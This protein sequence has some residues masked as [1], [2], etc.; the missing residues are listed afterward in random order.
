MLLERELVPITEAVERLVSLQAQVP[1]P[2]YIGLW[3]RL[4]NFH[5]GNLT[6][7]M[8]ERRVVR[9][10]LMRSILHLVTPEDYLLLRPALI[11][12]LNAFLGKLNKGPDLG[13][14]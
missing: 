11:R 14:L 8:Q 4:R 7:L 10:T 6:R 1:N 12:V 13:P 2:P 3:T 9:A 5:R